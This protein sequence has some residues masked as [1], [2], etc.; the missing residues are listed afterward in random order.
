[1]KS[2]FKCIFNHVLTFKNPLPDKGELQQ[3]PA[4]TAL[5]NTPLRGFHCAFI[6]TKGAA[7]GPTLKLES[8]ADD[9]YVE[10]TWSS[11]FPQVLTY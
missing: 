6:C 1:M 11:K 4:W 9:S 7:S 2:E 5:V 3:L 10:L 8:A